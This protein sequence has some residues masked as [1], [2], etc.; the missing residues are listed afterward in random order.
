MSHHLKV[1]LLR[2]ELANL[3]TVFYSEEESREEW[4]PPAGIWGQIEARFFRLRE[5]WQQSHGRATEFGRHVWEWL[6]RRTHPDEALLARLRRARSIELHHPESMAEG[7]AVAAWS[8]FLAVGRRRHW[9]WLVA[10]TLVAPLTILL[11]PLPGPNVIGYWFVYRAVH[12]GLILIGLGRVRRGLIPTTFRPDDSLDQPGAIEGVVAD[13][14]DLD[15]FL[16]RH[17]ACPADSP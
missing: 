5:R 6:H 12:H 15:D 1:Y 9:P 10:N 17:G 14:A 8:R 16:T 2:V 11:A 7:D 3:S 4:E 13:P